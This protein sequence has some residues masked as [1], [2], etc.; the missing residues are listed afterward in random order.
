MTTSDPPL[1]DPEDIV[2]RAEKAHTQ[3][4]EGEVLRQREAELLERLL[5][6]TIPPG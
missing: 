1:L 4:L 5:G 6:G 2:A 3:R